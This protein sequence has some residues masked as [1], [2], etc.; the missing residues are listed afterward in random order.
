[1]SGEDTHHNVPKHP[2]APRLKSV[3]K[4]PHIDHHATYK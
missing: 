1:M 4:T 3:Y 2:V